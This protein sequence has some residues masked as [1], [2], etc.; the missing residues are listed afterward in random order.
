VHPGVVDHL[1]RRVGGVEAAWGS[2]RAR[3]HRASGQDQGR[4]LQRARRVAHRESRQVRRQ[5]LRRRGHQ[6]HLGV[7]AMRQAG[8]QRKQTPHGVPDENERGA[9]VAGVADGSLEGGAD[10]SQAAP[11]ELGDPSLGPGDDVRAQSLGQPSEG[12]RTRERAG[13]DQ[14]RHWTADL[15]SGSPV[16]GFPKLVN[17]WRGCGSRPA[18]HGPRAGI[19]RRPSC[20]CLGCSPI[21]AG[22]DQCGHDHGDRHNM[23]GSREARDGFRATEDGHQHAHP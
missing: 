18:P 6:Q 7:D 11:L 23:P 21:D 9:V 5:A 13:G 20:G 3:P 22:R 2:D 15:L 19:G 4:E 1:R 8:A 12:R 14:N 10:G 17:P 16:E